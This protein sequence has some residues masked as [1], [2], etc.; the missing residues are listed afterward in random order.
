MYLKPVKARAPTAAESN[1]RVEPSLYNPIPRP[2]DY[3][4]HHQP[5]SFVSEGW[6][7]SAVHEFFRLSIEKMARKWT[8]IF[9]RINGNENKKKH[10]WKQ[11]IVCR[12]ESARSGSCEM[13]I[14][15]SR[16][17]WC[18][19]WAADVRSCHYT[20]IA[21]QNLYPELDL[22]QVY[23]SEQCTSVLYSTSLYILSL[24][25][26]GVLFLFSYL[27]FW[28]RIETNFR[29]KLTFFWTLCIILIR[30]LVWWWLRIPSGLIGHLSKS[31]TLKKI[32]LL[33]V[34]LCSYL[35]KK[36]LVVQYQDYVLKLMTDWGNAKSAHTH[37]GDASHI[38]DVK[39][40]GRD[41]EKRV[42]FA[43]YF[44]RFSVVK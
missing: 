42:Q 23:P 13:R 14:S 11:G 2:S 22:A 44:L 18:Y 26:F 24:H 10:E 17:I 8:L 19:W 32:L 3:S 40:P 36:L 27:M 21:L 33:T 38:L 1:R 31:Y 15:F 30:Y 25:S 41:F 35:H 7:N 28:R 4:D 5:K 20:L 37:L 29:W 6:K 39:D 43:K 9:V 34:Y 12:R 16:R